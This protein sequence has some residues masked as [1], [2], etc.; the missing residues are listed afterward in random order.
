MNGSAPKSPATGSQTSRPPELDSPNFSI[1]SMRLRD[2]SK[3]IADDDQD[4]H[5]R[6]RARSR[7]GTPESLLEDLDLCS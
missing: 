3:P 6:E 4:E 7:A 2:S 1:D 5:E